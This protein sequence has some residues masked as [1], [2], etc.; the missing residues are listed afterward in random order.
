MQFDTS[1]TYLTS[2]LFQE[3]FDMTGDEK[4]VFI[5][6][7]YSQ[8]TILPTVVLTKKTK[9]HAAMILELDSSWSLIREVLVREDRRHIPF[10]IL[11][12][13]FN[14]GE[15]FFIG[16]INPVFA[17]YSPAAFAQVGS[18]IEKDSASNDRY[19]MLGK[20]DVNDQLIYLTATAKYDK[21]T[22]WHLDDAFAFNDANEVFLADAHDDTLYAVF[23]HGGLKRKIGIQF[24]INN[25]KSII[26]V[27]LIW[28]VY[29]K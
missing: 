1:G 2:R 13:H 9:N 15:L 11:G 12:T 17:N 24:F 6:G 27:L 16:T 21:N 14:K 28:M 23:E 22:E 20:V 19:A 5:S 8:D 10:N 26:S 18:L 3:N 7:T 29:L 25:R 4:H